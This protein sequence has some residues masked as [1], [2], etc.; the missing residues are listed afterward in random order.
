MNKSVFAVLIFVLMISGVFAI[1]T[2][3]YVKTVSNHDVQISVY[4]TDASSFSMAESFIRKSDIYGD[5]KVTFSNPTGIDNFGVIVFVK[6]YGKTILNEKFEEY[7]VGDDV[8]VE[9][10]PP[11]VEPL[12]TPGLVE[13]N[14]SNESVISNE[15]SDDIILNESMN[16]TSENETESNIKPT[17]ITLDLTGWAVFGSTIL[18]N[19]IYYI[20]GGV[21]VFLIIVFFLIKKKK[22]K[23]VRIDKEGSIINKEIRVRKLS[24]VIKEREEENSKVKS[25]ALM[26][27]ER[28]LKEA[29]S[30]VL[31][32]K[33][34][35]QIR[36][37]E[38]KLREDEETL[39]RLRG[40]QN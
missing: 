12:K 38:R 40:G 32:L 1:N 6:R 5:V 26:E 10:L 20:I 9:V 3:I 14:E 17:V 34:D 18:S 29:Q 13:L 36:E 35:D 28:K 7:A 30:E 37:A 11:G 16:V 22:K 39:R 27:A 23:K 24:D 4:D 33:S 8:Y 25:D 31:R 15:S 21:V 2:D 19:S